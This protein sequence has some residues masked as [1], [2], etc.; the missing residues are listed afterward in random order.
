M[1]AI[2]KGFV[3]VE[4][5]AVFHIEHK[6]GGHVVSRREVEL[7]DGINADDFNIGQEYSIEGL[8]K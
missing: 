6:I 4:Q 3:T 7:K 2:F 5:N 1:K 8:T